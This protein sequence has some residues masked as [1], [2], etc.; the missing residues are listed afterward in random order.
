MNLSNGCQY[1]AASRFSAHCSVQ[2]SDVVKTNL[3]VFIRPKI[4]RD[5]AQ[6]RFETNT[7]YNQISEALEGNRIRLMPGTSR[8]S[9]PPFPTPESPD[10][11]TDNK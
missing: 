1:W 9:L 10:N 2:K 4:L 7:K 5:T 6:S 3:M 8:P 11:T